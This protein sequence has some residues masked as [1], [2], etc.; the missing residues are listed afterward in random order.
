MDYYDFGSSFCSLWTPV[1]GSNVFNSLSSLAVMVSSQNGPGNSQ[2]IVNR[3]E[4]VF[5]PENLNYFYLNGHRM[6]NQMR[7]FEGILN[8]GLRSDMS[9]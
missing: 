9:A 5:S 3:N 7:W 6:T 2:K 4:K 8:R 1:H